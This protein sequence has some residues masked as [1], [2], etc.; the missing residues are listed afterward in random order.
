MKRF[1]KFLLVILCLSG[2]SNHDFGSTKHLP[3]SSGNLNLEN[4]N[5]I[6]EP[7]LI[8]NG[9]WEFYWNKLL[10]PD[11]FTEDTQPDDVIPFPSYWNN[12]KIEGVNVQGHGF[13]TYRLQIEN[14]PVDKILAIKMRNA[15]TSYKLWVNEKLILENGKVGKDKSTSSPGFLPDIQPFTLSDG[16][17]TIVIQISNFSHAK[18]GMRGDIII[19]E[20][21]KV[22]EIRERNIAIDIFLIGTI[23]I[24]SIYHL[25]LFYLSRKDNSTLYFGL[26]CF[27]VALRIACTGE[28]VIMNY[29]DV[30]WELLQ[31]LEYFTFVATLPTFLLFTH[32]L[33]SNQTSLPIIKGFITISILLGI[34]VIMSPSAVYSYIANPYQ[35]VI[36]LCGLYVLYVLLLSL[37][38]EPQ[39]RSESYIFLLGY[40]VL[41]ISVIY[42][43]LYYNFLLQK[44]Y[45]APMGLVAFI[46]SQSFLLSKRFSA[47]FN[48][49][50]EY[51][52]SLE[53]KVST[54]TL[55]LE[56]KNESLE[57]LNKEKDSMVE[58]VAHD[59]KSPFN[60]ILGFTELLKMDGKLN[61][62]QQEY[63]RQIESVV[64]T[65]RGLIRDILDVHAYEYD[66]FKLNYTNVV[67]SEFIDEWKTKYAQHLKTKNQEL[68]INVP[69]NLKLD[70]DVDLLSRILDNL[71][72]NAIKFSEVNKSIWITAQKVD[73]TLNID[74]R[75]E[76][77]GFTSEDQLLMFKRFQKLSAKPTAGE[78]SNGLGLSIIKSL[79]TKLGGEIHI[80]SKHSV[81]STFSIILPI[82]EKDI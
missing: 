24:M 23:L 15:M 65:G 79:I 41:F 80:S 42:D 68:I 3:I 73:K 57:Q 40:G 74:V 36:L 30:S 20:L 16:H 52:N 22:L 31:K 72:N 75:D 6:N 62:K 64:G 63:L 58:I 48:L 59:L 60:N 47:A 56:E 1:I 27:A 53:Q 18:G 8:L 14:A 11:A 21:N 50:E 51:S 4:Y 12:L 7:P 45:L 37:K 67:F 81:G 25:G 38:Y 39:R 33:Y 19:G 70:V 44:G 17:L 76:G 46:F 78:S 43:V 10:A 77:Q 69:K 71:I 13:A 66:N 26:L 32:A 55:E 9:N 35:I 61:T 29:L 54:R 28:F 34:L 49:V 5:L 2:C 82:K